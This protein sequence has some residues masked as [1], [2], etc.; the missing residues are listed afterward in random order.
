MVDPDVKGA[1]DQLLFSVARKLLVN[2]AK[3]SGAGRVC[4]S[5]RSLDHEVELVVRDD[6]RGID[7]AAIRATVVRV[8]VPARAQPLG[9]EDAPAPRPATLRSAPPGSPAARPS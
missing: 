5:V 6:G 4:I 8:R 1:S 3:H 7:A 2:A 9:S